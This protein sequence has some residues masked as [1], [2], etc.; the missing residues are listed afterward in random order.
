[1]ASV[2]K[3]TGFSYSEISVNTVI[4]VALNSCLWLLCSC[5]YIH[6]AYIIMRFPCPIGEL[7]KHKAICN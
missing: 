2:Y 1:M 7:I 4:C 5:S 6:I 3:F